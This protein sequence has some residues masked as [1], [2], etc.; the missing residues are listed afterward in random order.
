MSRLTPLVFAL[1]LSIISEVH[2]QVRILGTEQVPSGFNSTGRLLKNLHPARFRVQ[3]ENTSREPERGTLAAEVVGNLHTVHGLA[4]QH[5]E[6]AG[7]EKRT[8]LVHW[9]YP[10]T[11]TYEGAPMGPVKVPGASWGHEL[12]VVWKNAEGKV[13]GQGKTVFAVEVDGGEVHLRELTRVLTLKESQT[14]RWS[15]YLAN[16]AFKPATEPWDL[17]VTRENIPLTSARAGIGPSGKLTYLFDL[18]RGLTPGLLRVDLKNKRYRLAQAWMLEQTKDEGPVARKLPHRGNELTAIVAMFPRRGEGSGPGEKIKLAEGAILILELEGAHHVPSVPVADLARKGDKQFGPLPPLLK[19]SEGQSM[20]SVDDLA[21]MQTARRLAIQQGLALKP[22]IKA[23]PF[24]ARIIS[25]ESVP[26]QMHMAGLAGAYTRKNYSLQVGPGQRMNVWVLTPHGI[27]PFP[28]VVALHQTVEEGK[29]EPA[30]LGGNQGQ[31]GFGPFLASRGFVVIAPD[32]PRTGERFN[33]RMENAYST[34]AQ[35]KSDPNYNLLGQ[36][37]RDHRRV[38]DFLLTLPEVDKKRIGAMGHSLG[39]ESTALLSAV[40]ERIRAAVISCPFSLLQ[41]LDKADEAY[42]LPGSTILPQS[43]RKMLKA[44]PG[45]RQLPFDFDDAM[46]CWA[47]RPIFFHGVTD[48]LP[49]FTNITRTAQA[50]EALGQ[51]YRELG[52]ADR[53]HSRYSRQGHCFPGWVQ[54][55]AL[56][57]LEFWLAEDQVGSIFPKEGRKK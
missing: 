35:E 51:V 7:G 30:A 1:G 50:V 22:E 4:P 39:G 36:R 31:L 17:G 3:L 20:N 16:P 38:V 29:D 5:L 9:R 26:A 12:H 28:A 47:P 24:E 55:D 13:T 10:G 44:P 32:S 49:Q 53:F 19:K 14:L 34:S 27:G 41:T 25:E 33:P 11:I 43:W 48:D 56:D 37:L 2:G 52:H 46:V 54:P 21:P 45:Q 18:G 57:W 8:I 42:A 40:D 15:G 23:V 6:L